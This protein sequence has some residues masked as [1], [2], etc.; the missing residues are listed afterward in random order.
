[1]FTSGKLFLMPIAFLLPPATEARFGL[2]QPWVLELSIP[3]GA[4]AYW[5]ARARTKTTD[6]EI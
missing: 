2:D 5:I 6:G 4:I 3:L 1:M